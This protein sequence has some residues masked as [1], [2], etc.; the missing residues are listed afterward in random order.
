[1][2]NGVKKGGSPAAW[3]IVRESPGLQDLW[4]LHVSAEG[5]HDANAAEQFIA[6]LDETTSH[7]ISVSAQQDG[8]FTVTNGRTHMTKTYGPGSSAKGTGAAG[9]ARP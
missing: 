6:N 2:N 1:M 3:R 5:G 9:G 4:Q 7:A 8:R